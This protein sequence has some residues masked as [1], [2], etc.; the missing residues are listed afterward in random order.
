[1]IGVFHEK[2]EPAKQYPKQVQLNILP[3]DRIALSS[4]ALAFE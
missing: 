4:V 2:R 1:M 3:V